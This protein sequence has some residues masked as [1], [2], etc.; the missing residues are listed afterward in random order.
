MIRNY[1]KIAW[2]NL[3]NQPFFTSINVFGLAISIA[4]ALLISLYI[5]DELSYNKMFADAERIYR[6]DANLKFGGAAHIVAKAPAP[7]AKA[8][9]NDCPQVEMVT[10]IRDV[11]GILIKKKN[12]QKNIKEAHATYVDSNFFEMFG[13]DVLEGTVDDALKK[14]KTVVLTK[15]VAQKHFG[16]ESTL[17]QQILL[18]NNKLCTVTGV[19]NDFPKNSLLRNHTV[20]IST[21]GYGKAQ[22]NAWGDFNFF[23]FIK[24]QP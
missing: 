18:N 21:A 10:R 5:Y 2:R 22:E 15:T 7:M 14:P 11:S 4:G 20:F 24:L 9:T 3:K 19:I 17:G 6:V 8:I 13:V 12:T 23:T 1:F 16:S